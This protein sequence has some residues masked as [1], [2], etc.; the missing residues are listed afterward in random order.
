MQ[1]SKGVGMRITMA[2]WLGNQGMVRKLSVVVFAFLVTLGLPLAARAVTPPSVTLTPSV[3]SPQMLGTPVTWTAK[4]LNAVAGHTYDYQF[5]VTLNGQTQIVSD[6]ALPNNFTWVPHTVEGAY[7][8]NL[9]VRDI[10]ATPYS[11]FAPLSVPFTLKPWVTAPLA[12]GVVNPTSHPLIALFSAPPCG[13]GHQI[14]VRFHPTSSTG[15]QNPNSMTTNLIPCSKNSA[16]FYVGGMYPTTAYLMH[17]EEYA[18]SNSG[19]HGR[20]FAV[21]YRSASGHR[22]QLSDQCAG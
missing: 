21:H 7:T 19:E 10:T 16:N 12:T 18:G 8:F 2:T 20:R 5:S 1:F 22:Q 13:A 14:L 15:S 11:A 4:V 6:F 3:A 9:V 17:W